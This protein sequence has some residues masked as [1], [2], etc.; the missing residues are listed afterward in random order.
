MFTFFY[1]AH[2]TAA[3][4]CDE[5]VCLSLCV[6]CVCVCVCQWSY[7]WNHTSS[8]L[9][10][11]LVHVTHGRDSV[12]FWRRS[13]TLCRINS[14]LIYYFLFVLLPDIYSFWRNKDFHKHCLDGYPCWTRGIRGVK[15][16]WFQMLWWAPSP[17]KSRLRP[18][19]LHERRTE[20]N[21]WRRSRKGRRVIIHSFISPQNVMA[22]KE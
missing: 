9:H 11:I 2:D 14:Q 13:D 8:D 6:V 15:L 1:S 22:K 17:R 16:A 19:S 5:R 12:L 20:L 21:G 7:L 18:V 4:Y 10:Q 3:E